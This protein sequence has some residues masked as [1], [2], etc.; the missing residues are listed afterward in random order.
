MWR[1]AVS[2]KLSLLF[3]SFVFEPIRLPSQ[4]AS[5]PAS[6]P[7]PL[8]IPSS[9]RVTNGHHYTQLLHE[10]WE[11]NP[12]SSYRADNTATNRLEIAQCLKVPSIDIRQ[13]TATCNFSSRESESLLNF[14]GI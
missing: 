3:S 6:L 11:S 14:V 7:P 1:P 9:A 5:G 8:P 2:G 13:P 10:Y 4:S 12:C